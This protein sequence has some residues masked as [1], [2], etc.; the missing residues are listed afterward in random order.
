MH[1]APPQNGQQPRQVSAAASFMAAL[2]SGQA[3]QPHRSFSV[4]TTSSQA[5]QESHDAGAHL[6]RSQSMKNP[7]RTD[8]P[9]SFAAAGAGLQSPSPP[10]SHYTP[11]AA[12]KHPLFAHH[13]IPPQQQPWSPALSYK[14]DPGPV[15]PITIDPNCQTPP[16]PGST[17]SSTF[18]PAT[19]FLQAFSSRSSAPSEIAPDAQGARV[20]DYILGKVL[21]RGGF[22]TVRAATHVKT[23]EEFACKIVT[24]DDLSDESGSAARFEDEIRIWQTLPRHPA[25]LPLLDIMRTE[26]ATFMI[27]PRLEGS[28]LDVLRI[29][30]GSESTARK[31]FPGCVTAVA[32]LHEGFEGFEGQMMHGDL[33]LD[34]FLVDAHG[35]VCVGDFGMACKVEICPPKRGPS[36]ASRPSNLPAHLQARGRLSSAPDSPRNPSRSPARRRDTLATT[37]MNQPGHQPCPS[38]SLPYACPELLHPSPAGPSLAQDIWALGIILYALLTGRLPFNDSFDPRLQMK[39]LRGQWEEPY[40]GHEW[41][42]A[43][44]GTLHRDPLKRWDIRRVRESDA[45]TGWREV[46]TKSR[47]RSRARV[48]DRGRRAPGDS[49]IHTHHPDGAGRGRDRSRSRASP[50]IRHDSQEERGRFL[51]A[52]TDGA[53]SR[54]QSGTRK[55]ATTSRPSS[56]H[57]SH[58]HPEALAAELDTITITRGRSAQREERTPNS[59]AGSLEPRPGN[60]SRSPSAAGRPPRP[61]SGAEQRRGRSR[62]REAAVPGTAGW[63][64]AQFAH[65]RH[66]A[67]PPGSGTHSGVHSGAHTPPRETREHPHPHSAGGSRPPTLGFELDVV[68]ENAPARGRDAVGAGGSRSKSRGRLDRLK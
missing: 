9:L 13:A 6:G 19:A 34:N 63:W 27:M 43:L 31:W 64:E 32:A 20:L 57:K 18:S 55:P 23:G 4:G 11:P 24:R 46:R 21:G 47:S 22:S 60:G 66:D 62:A 16:S 25:I 8:G 2:N 1:P 67:T 56:M 53:R 58:L 68:D 5:S 30:G 29:E 45:V 14:S 61:L 50:H 59:S 33:K 54:S 65:T 36:P 35:G 3:Y 26:Y 15:P 40:V 41:I 7:Q 52:H 51:H 44:H 28:L 48:G 39:I 42:E 12:A 37:D 38:A 49:P 17:V 10:A